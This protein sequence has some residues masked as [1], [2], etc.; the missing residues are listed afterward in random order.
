[1]TE[2]RKVIC[3]NVCST[4]KDVSMSA[5]LNNFNTNNKMLH[6][7]LLASVTHTSMQL[8][9]KLSLQ[10]L[11]SQLCFP[12]RQHLTLPEQ[13][14]IFL[15][16]IWTLTGATEMHIGD[17]FTLI[18]M[19]KHQSRGEEPKVSEVHPACLLSVQV[20]N[21]P[22]APQ[23]SRKIP[24]SSSLLPVIKNSREEP[25]DIYNIFHTR[26]MEGRSW[27]K[28]LSF[29]KVSSQHSKKEKKK[30]QK[31]STCS[32]Q[33]NVEIC[34]GAVLKLSLFRALGCILRGSEAAGVSR[35]REDKVTGWEH[36]CMELYHNRWREVNFRREERRRRST[37]GRLVLQW[38][39]STARTSLITPSSARRW[40][41]SCSH[42]CSVSHCGLTQFGCFRELLSAFSA[43]FLIL[44]LSLFPPGISFQSPAHMWNSPV[45][46][47]CARLNP[48][49]LEATNVWRLSC[50]CRKYCYSTNQSLNP[51]TTRNRDF[52]SHSAAMMEVCCWELRDLQLGKLWL[53]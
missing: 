1:M 6:V 26:G 3:G 14:V 33:I 39:T 28:H 41:V 25:K 52:K 31:M 5:F 36:S 45:C 48:R 16:F 4:F 2:T 32:S 47:V 38:D 43:L 8:N 49:V 15:F 51:T 44:N 35:R 29:W 18:L 21:L 24:H 34:P 19:D 22:K 12:R 27:I 13:T 10:Q 37:Q 7:G 20:R 53:K 30:S 50:H 46:L 17:G 23:S 40:P 9:T 11:I 42:A